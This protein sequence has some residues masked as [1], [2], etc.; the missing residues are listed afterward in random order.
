MG[1]LMKW[2]LD[3]N[4]LKDLRLTLCHTLFAMITD[5]SF[6]VGLNTSCLLCIPQFVP[7]RVLCMSMGFSCIILH[8]F[9]GDYIKLSTG[10]L[11]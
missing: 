11:R 4:I 8:H 10:Y 6:T 5:F 7:P 9:W 2:G 3:T 1:H